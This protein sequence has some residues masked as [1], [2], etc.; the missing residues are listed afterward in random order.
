M[1]ATCFQVS[2]SKRV[3]GL[4]VFR[5][6]S[7]RS[8]FWDITLLVQSAGTGMCTIIARD[9]VCQ[10]RNPW[11]CAR[12]FYPTNGILITFPIAVIVYFLRSCKLIIGCFFIWIFT[13]KVEMWRRWSV[14]LLCI[15]FLLQWVRSQ[16]WVGCWTTNSHPKRSMVM[17]PECP[18]LARKSRIFWNL[19]NTR[20]SSCSFL[21][22]W[23]EASLLLWNLVLFVSQ[24]LSAGS[25]LT[26]PN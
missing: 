1:N 20:T 4:R 3:V 12:I 26:C 25:A 13:E 19:H 6:N 9:F 14:V 7:V 2:P 8:H 21:H 5:S 16:G 15:V 24:K 11:S 18:W 10:N 23:V 17:T 22:G